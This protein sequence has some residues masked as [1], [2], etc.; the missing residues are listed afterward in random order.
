M[1][2]LPSVD[3]RLV[4]SPFILL[5]VFEVQLRVLKPYHVLDLKI[6]LVIVV[7]LLLAFQSL[8]L[9][10]D[11]KLVLESIDVMLLYNSK[12]EG[13]ISTLFVPLS[14]SF[15]GAGPRQIGLDVIDGE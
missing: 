4:L 8:Q 2:K 6:H 1:L 3:L 5:P 12:V 11:L 7:F 9:E 14:W 10:W 15:F 13:L